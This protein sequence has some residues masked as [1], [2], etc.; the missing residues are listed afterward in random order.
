M[1]I[2]NRLLRSIGYQ[3]QTWWYLQYCV[4]SWRMREID[5]VQSHALSGLGDA[6]SH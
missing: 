5:R 6:S 1:L 3:I 4:L 2:A